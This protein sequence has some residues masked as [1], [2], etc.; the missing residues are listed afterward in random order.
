MRAEPLHDSLN[1]LFCDVFAAVV[2]WATSLLLWFLKSHDVDFNIS[3]PFAFFCDL[4]LGVI[5]IFHANNYCLPQWKKRLYHLPVEISGNLSR[6]FWSNGK[7][8]LFPD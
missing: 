7:R 5:E 8:P 2:V 3:V 6:N 4:N 1:P